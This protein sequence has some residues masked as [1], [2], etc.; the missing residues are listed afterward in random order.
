MRLPGRLFSRLSNILGLKMA[1]GP[2]PK[3]AELE[4][5]ARSLTRQGSDFDPVELGAFRNV[6]SVVALEIKF[7][8][9]S[10]KR[11]LMSYFYLL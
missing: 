1:S 10:I 7:N 9:N 5:R 8:K 3:E 6:V 11:H 4:I 2:K